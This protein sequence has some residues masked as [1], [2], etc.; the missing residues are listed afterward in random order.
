ML[1]AN[2]RMPATAVVVYRAGLA[3]TATHRVKQNN[4]NNY[5]R[6]NIGN[7]RNIVLLS[8][9]AYYIIIWSAGIQKKKKKKLKFTKPCVKKIVVVY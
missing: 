7:R 5:S 2:A 1:Y 9:G 3:V 4:D 6:D 8:V